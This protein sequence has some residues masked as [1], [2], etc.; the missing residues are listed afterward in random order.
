MYKICFY[1]Q[2]DPLSPLL[3]EIKKIKKMLNTNIVS[4]LY[5]TFGGYFKNI[6]NYPGCF[7]KPGDRF[8][9]LFIYFIILG[10]FHVYCPI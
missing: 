5:L 4:F 10:I 9:K 7:I 6:L 8:L 1:I 2:G 3:T